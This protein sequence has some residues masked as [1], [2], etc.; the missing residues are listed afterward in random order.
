METVKLTKK[1]MGIQRSTINRAIAVESSWMCKTFQEHE[2]ELKEKQDIIRSIM[3]DHKN[4][5]LGKNV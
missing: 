1:Q 5:K 4:K 2:L 3:K